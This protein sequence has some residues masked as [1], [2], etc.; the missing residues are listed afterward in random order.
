MNLKV[1]NRHKYSLNIETVKGLD[2]MGSILRVFFN[3]EDESHDAFLRI[4]QF[5]LR[6]CHAGKNAPDGPM[7][8]VSGLNSQEYT[9]KF[10]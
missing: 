10:N 4:R 3:T 1:I 9:L 7:I 8:M 5:G 2:I 6:C